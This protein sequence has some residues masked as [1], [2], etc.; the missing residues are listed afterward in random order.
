MKAILSVFDKSGIVDFARELVR[1]NWEVLSTGGTAKALR[2]AKVPV[3][4]VSDY[5]GFPEMMEGRLKAMH[6]KILGGLLA[7]RGKKSHLADA[8]KNK[9]EPIDLVVVN[10]Y[11][12][13]ETVRKK[14]PFDETIEMIDIGGP[15][16]LRAAAKNFKHV[17]V[18]TDPKDYP[19]VLE[20]LRTGGLNVEQKKDL[21]RKVFNRTAFYDAEIMKFL[22]PK[23]F[24][25]KIVLP[26]VKKQ[27]MRYGENP[28]QQAAFY[29]SP[30]IVEPCIS[31]AAQLQGKELSYNNIMDAD[32]ALE[33]VKEFSGPTAAV[34][35]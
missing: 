18:V 20:S 9:I 33:I 26:Y 1:M 19:W 11:P 10:L 17:V 15:T 28:H 27:D 13:E 6:P 8:K 21:A 12:F 25:E 30:E 14:A 3:T 35:K 5:T 31:T 22:S 4:E 23:L 29:V 7:D 32:A 16:M 2:D 34:I 24:P